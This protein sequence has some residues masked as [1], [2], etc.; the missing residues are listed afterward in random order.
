MNVRPGTS[1][2]FIEVSVGH[3]YFQASKSGSSSYRNGIFFDGDS[4]VDA[5]QDLHDFRFDDV[6]AAVECHVWSRQ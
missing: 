2:Y 3:H 4:F 6:R 1:I 5:T